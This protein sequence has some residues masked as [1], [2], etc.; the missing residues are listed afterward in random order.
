MLNGL[1]YKC[2]LFFISAT[3]HAIIIVV[4]CKLWKHVAQVHIIKII[5]SK[6]EE[7]IC[8]YYLV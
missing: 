3:G 6:L 7:K 5:T 1:S 4:D 2:D 8:P